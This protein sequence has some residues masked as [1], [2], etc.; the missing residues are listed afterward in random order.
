MDRFETYKFKEAVDIIN[1]TYL[2]WIS[3]L[4]LDTKYKEPMKNQILILAEM[5]SEYKELWIEKFKGEPDIID[6][7]NIL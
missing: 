6:D 4:K 5:T 7:L 1:K 3:I 2:N